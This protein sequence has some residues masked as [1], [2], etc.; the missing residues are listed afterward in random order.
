MYVSVL[1]SYGVNGACMMTNGGGKKMGVSLF[2][3]SLSFSFYL[4]EK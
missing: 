1:G 3:L 2:S 4:N